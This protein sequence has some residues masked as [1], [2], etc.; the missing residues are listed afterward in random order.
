[1]L[2][3]VTPELPLK[4]QGRPAHAGCAAIDAALAISYSDLHIQIL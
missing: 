2:V 1:M 4:A 3:S